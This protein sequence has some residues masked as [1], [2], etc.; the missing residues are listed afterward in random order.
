MFSNVRELQFIDISHFNLQ[1]VENSWNMFMNINNLKYANLYNVVDPKGII[2]G[3]DLNS[4]FS[5][6]TFWVCQ[7]DKLVSRDGVENACCH[8]DLE[9]NICE[10]DTSNLFRVIFASDVEYPNGFIND[11]RNDIKFILGQGYNNKILPDQPI[12]FK[13]GL[14]YE[15]YLKTP[16]NLENFFNSKNDPNTK[17]IKSIDVILPGSS[18]VSSLESM[19]QGCSSLESITLSYIDTSSV[20]SFKSMFRDCSSLKKVDLSHFDTSLAQDMERMFSGCESLE[21]IDL[22]NFNTSLVTSMGYMFYGCESLKYLDLSYLDTS[23][24]EAMNNMFQNCKNLKVLDISTFNMAELNKAKNMFM[25]V[26]NLK[27]INIYDVQNTEDYIKESELKNIDN[28]TICQKEDIIISEKN[29]YYNCCYF[30]IETDKCESYNYI[31]IYYNQEVTY[32]NGFNHNH[33]QI[34][35]EINS[36]KKNISLLIKITSIK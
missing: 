24:V 9:A 11:Y 7:K 15:I 20:T 26:L 30:N 19:F 35:T 32:N 33:N 22:S 36:E 34:S 8:I 6:I 16:S 14:T 4:I 17:Q 29:A 12:T 5:T 2:A 23:L 31:T 18:S 1:N 10:E 3:S 27:Y 13:A 28:L 21:N 25:N